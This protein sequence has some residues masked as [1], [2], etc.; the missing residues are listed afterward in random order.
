MRRYIGFLLGGFALLTP[1]LA[2]NGT[3]EAVNELYSDPIPHE[4]KA[5]VYPPE[6]LKAGV[7]GRITVAFVVDAEGRVV[8]PAIR[9]KKEK[10]GD[11]RLNEAVLAAAKLWTFSPAFD[12]G[13][14]VPRAVYVTVG[15]YLKGR[16]NKPSVDLPQHPDVAG[17][18]PAKA[19]NESDPD[20][21]DELM[22]RKL[23][24]EAEF[25]F[26]IT[27]EGRVGA[28]KVLFASDAAFVTAGMATL[29][30][31][32]FEPAKQGPI[33]V[34]SSKKSPMHFFVEGDQAKPEDV[35]TANGITGLTAA[36]VTKAP[37]PLMMFAPV[38][39]RARAAA[40]ESGEAEVEFVIRADGRTEYVNVMSASQPE[41]GA[42]LV[43][44][45]ETWEFRPAVKSGEHV[46]LTLRVHQRFALNETGD[47]PRVANA[48]AA[49][50]ASAKGLDRPL[51]PL[52]RIGPRYP[53]ALLAEKPTGEA[54][55]EF[56]IDRT[57]RAR[58]PLV[59]S[60]THEAFGWAAATAISQWVFEPPMRNGEA[61]DVRVSIPVSFSPPTN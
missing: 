52:W 55:I 30:R 48:L 43:A 11:P 56:I 27:P 15:F 3:P 38:Y 60:A 49:G 33:P 7:E 44:A 35:L 37:E 42:A 32:R 23:P 2:Q 34:V 40:G 58:L 16:G 29:D 10:P 24:G 12:A 46:A 8:D 39:P 57:G 59:S 47:E 26:Q 53:A 31:W 17:T 6:A 50:I 19:L 54:M 51:A 13:K 25:E 28:R 45:V 18:R 61:V 41:F 36:G 4:W 5:P 9:E 20:Y 22:A 21:P 1:A 14:K